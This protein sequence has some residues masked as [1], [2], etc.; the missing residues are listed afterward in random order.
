MDREALSLPFEDASIWVEDA[1][2]P[3]R[4][5][6]LV[7]VRKKYGSLADKAARYF[8]QS[9]PLGDAVAAE[10]S[11]LPP[12]HGAKMF[13]QALEQG[14]ATVQGAPQAL[15]DFFSQVEAVPLWLNRDL[16]EL[17]SR[18]HLR[19]GILCG[20]ILGSTALPL[21]YR[22]AAGIK[23]LMFSSQS[24]KRSV[25]RLSETNR[26]FVETTSPGGL[27]IR[28]PGWKTTL[29]VRLMHA[30]MRRLLHQS[31][32]KPWKTEDWGLPI[33]QVDLA[34]T[35]LLFSVSLLQH[36][37]HIG[38]RFSAL[39]SESVMHLWRYAGYL[40]G[41]DC[42]LLTSTETEG[43]QLR[44][45]ILD[46]AGNPD[47]DSIHLTASLMET[48]MPVMMASIIPWLMP[49]NPSHGKAKRHSL[50]AGLARW[51][52]PRL[53]FGAQAET[54]KQQLAHFC[55]GLSQHIL[56]NKVAAELHYPETLWRI[57]APAILRSVVTPLEWLR[58]LVPGGS[59][60]AFWAGQSQIKR[61]MRSELF[62]RRP[63]F[64]P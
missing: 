48:A 20:V 24:L 30:Q 45:L 16:L 34:A 5:T 38:F 18:T 9:D 4:Y 3:T 22:S 21:A 43:L 17:G 40:L 27:A 28:A 2:F 64:K 31:K 46:V 19:C 41:I 11:A 8:M 39:E 62:A 42:A 25:R 35:Q 58:R 53:G 49:G 63:S 51:L 50:L 7:E 12:T 54:Y 61:L 1:W 15:R 55:Y 44:S 14:M 52:S 6:A 13:N 57:A 59:K 47:P 36:L 60:L 56:G 32:T 33:N 37:R 23:A 29:K 10:L 26:F